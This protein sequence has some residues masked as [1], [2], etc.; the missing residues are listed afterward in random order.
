M[1]DGEWESGPGRLTSGAWLDWAIKEKAALFVLEHRY[2]GKSRPTE[3][4]TTEELQWLSS[5]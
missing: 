1:I 4:I 3:K 2:Y 5:R